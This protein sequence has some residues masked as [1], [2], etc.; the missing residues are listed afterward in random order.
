[1]ISILNDTPYARESAE[2]AAAA[3]QGQWG[4]GSAF[5]YVTPV[6]SEANT[7]VAVG[8]LGVIFQE[9]IDIEGSEDDH[10]AIADESM[11]IF[12]DQKGLQMEDDEATNNSSGAFGSASYGDSLY[13]TATGYL[14]TSAAGDFVSG[15]TAVA[16]FL[17]FEADI[18]YFELL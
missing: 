8:L 3:A 1:M 14:T 17:K 5:G 13:L 11:V 6:A 4:L 7:K 9:T 2:L 16:K 12:A 18:L 15:S 10:D